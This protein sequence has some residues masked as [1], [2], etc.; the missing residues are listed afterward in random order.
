MDEPLFDHE[1]LDVYRLELEFIAWLT[2]LLTELKVDSAS[3]T[4]EV[5]D[6]VDRAGLSA[7]LNTA[8]GNAK[9][10]RQIRAKYF[11]D[12]RGSAA[13]AAACLDVLVAM[14]ACSRDR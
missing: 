1:K 3:T 11:D 7:V 6:Q 4:R 9:R 12:A 10:Q 2:D 14:R 8:E 13:E 5:R